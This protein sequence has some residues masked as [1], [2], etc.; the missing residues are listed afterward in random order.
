MNKKTKMMML[1]AERERRELMD[2]AAYRTR[3]GGDI[4][5]RFRDGQG[6]ERYDD[7]RF[8]PTDYYEPPRMESY[9]PMNTIGFEA[10]YDYPFSNEMQSRGGIRQKGFSDSNMLPQI[11]R[12]Y[13]ERKVREM[14]N[15]DG[16]TGEKWDF[17]T[18]EKLMQQKKIRCEP[19]E[20]Y[21]VLNMMYSDYGV[22]MRRYGI[23]MPDIYIDLAKAWLCDKDAPEWK[24]EMYFESIAGK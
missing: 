9:R 16:S 2:D 23:D 17:D 1:S 7:G 12:E 19:A 15:E 11:T 5:D 20:F 4:D 21:L 3:E 24:T 13:A 14:Q 10:R 18:V 22:V 6:R 8:A